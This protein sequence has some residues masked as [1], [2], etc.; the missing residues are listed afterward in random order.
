MEREFPAINWQ[1]TDA[2][3]CTSL[4]MTLQVKSPKTNFKMYY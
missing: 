3:A 2:D 1:T 4:A